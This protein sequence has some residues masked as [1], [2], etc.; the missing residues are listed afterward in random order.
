MFGSKVI[1]RKVM[2]KYYVGLL[3]LLFVGCKKQV[4]DTQRQ[5]VL[6]SMPS[7]E[8][9]PLYC[10]DDFDDLPESNDDT[11]ETNSENIRASTEPRNNSN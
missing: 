3:M 10:D 5:Y 1:L 2:K 6:P 11:E 9:H 8:D 7:C 4:S